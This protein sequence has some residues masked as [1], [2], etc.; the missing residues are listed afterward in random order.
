MQITKKKMQK[1]DL[2][3]TNVPGSA[4]TS[5]NP[6][7][8]AMALSLVGSRIARPHGYSVTYPFTYLVTFSLHPFAFTPFITFTNWV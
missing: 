3:V 4:S 2:T 7:G 8:P 6:I 5:S 1:K